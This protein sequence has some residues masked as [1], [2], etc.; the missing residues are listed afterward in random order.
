MRS[1]P[2]RA[3]FARSG[4]RAIAL[5]TALALPATLLPVALPIL[6]AT[7]AQAR[8][9]PASFADLAAQLLPAVVNISSSTMIA[10]QSTPDQ[11][12]PQFPPGSPFEKFFHDFMN[13]NHPGGAPDDAP[14]RMQSLGSGFIVDPSGIVV[15][16]NH[17]ID[18]ADQITVTLQ[19]GTNLKAKLIGHDSKADLAVLRVDAGHPL[20]AVPWGDSGQQRVG[21]WVVAIGN[22]FGLG[23]SVTAGI[24]SARGRD[25]RQ[26]PY[27]DFI[28]TDAPINRGNSGGPLFDIDGQVIGINTAIYSPSGG[29]IGIGFAIPSNE[30]KIVVDQL[31]KY[32]HAR[33]GWL[34]VRIQEVTPDIADSLGLKPPSGA[35]VAGVSDGGPAAAAKLH[36]GDVILSFNGHA[37][38]DMRVLPRTVAET[39]IGSAVP[40]VIWRDGKQQTLSVTVA[41][42]PG[43]N[44]K[45]A[46][47]TPPAK[48]KPP[49]ASRIAGLGIELSDLN[50]AARSKYQISAD[51]KGV[52]VTQVAPDSPAAS[53]GLKPGDVIVE[54]QQAQVSTPADVQS[55]VDSVRKQNRRSVLML[56]QG[57]GG[58]RWVPL[59][60]DASG[61]PGNQ[62]SPG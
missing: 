27:D 21:D 37:I 25:I 58:M 5:S 51:Q 49:A 11:P 32:H 30:A 9:A 17:V 10:A 55:R 45:Q 16:N 19:D 20:P 46:S 42:L 6:A 61:G 53:R 57:Q 3:R 24:I 18:G 35:L 44:I 38:K 14:R 7:P 31:I 39:E 8:D 56:I 15:T 52:V 50:D 47:A 2:M 34:G 59:P 28:Q 23:G 36:N 22:P 26:G 13:R 48:P 4:V 12:M 62:L 54:V 29:S 40:L 60:L 43:D 33:R 1:L 41:E